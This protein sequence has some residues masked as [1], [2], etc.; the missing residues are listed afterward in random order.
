MTRPLP[1]DS[2]LIFGNTNTNSVSGSGAGSAGL[3][4]MANEPRSMNL[5]TA[6]QALASGVIGERTGMIGDLSSSGGMG[7]GGMGIGGPVST[8]S[9]VD[10]AD[11]G[12]KQS[13]ALLEL[14]QAEL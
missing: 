14:V 3:K 6:A 10:S 7:M 12:V 9:L 2:S 4:S 5:G 13:V 11:A 1:S 8:A